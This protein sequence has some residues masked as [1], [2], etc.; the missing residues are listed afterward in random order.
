M[1]RGEAEEKFKANPESFYQ[2][3]DVIHKNTKLKGFG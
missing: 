1:F 3:N 2:M